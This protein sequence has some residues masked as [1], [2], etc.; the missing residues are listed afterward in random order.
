MKGIHPKVSK[1]EMYWQDCRKRYVGQSASHKK[2]GIFSVA[3]VWRSTWY[4][5]FLVR[6]SNVQS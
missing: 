1:R 5:S 2:T 4:E 6:T 3:Y